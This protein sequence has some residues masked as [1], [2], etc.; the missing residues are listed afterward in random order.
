MLKE[1]A[2]AVRILELPYV[3]ELAQAVRILEL[4][5]VKGASTSCPYTG[6]ALC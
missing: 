5:Y 1:L 3:K 4:L 6:V 2:Q